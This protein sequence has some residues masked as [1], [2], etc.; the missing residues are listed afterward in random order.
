MG[1]EDWHLPTMSSLVEM[2]LAGIPL[3]CLGLCIA[4]W[5]SELAHSLS[6][7]ICK[8][9]SWQT[10]CSEER[11]GARFLNRTGMSALGRGR[12]SAERI[13]SQ[14]QCTKEHCLMLQPL[15]AGQQQHLSPPHRGPT[16]LSAA[17]P[18]EPTTASGHKLRVQ[19]P[20]LV[21]PQQ[22]WG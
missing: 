5:N 6:G 20:D 13:L 7:R 16:A 10:S 12:I 22:T 2:S 19:P 9:D 15:R 8:I 11:G 18:G 14:G 4:P 3:L 17:S 1:P 21:C